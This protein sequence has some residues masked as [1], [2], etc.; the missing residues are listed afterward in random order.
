[1]TRNA[2]LEPLKVHVQRALDAARMTKTQLMREYP[3]ITPQGYMRP[4]DNGS[5]YRR[6]GLALLALPPQLLE[7]LLTIQ[8]S[9]GWTKLRRIGNRKRTLNENITKVRLLIIE[10]GSAKPGLKKTSLARKVA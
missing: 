5:L 1:M 9:V 4:T 2:N 3:F 7:K 10:L 8:E 6:V